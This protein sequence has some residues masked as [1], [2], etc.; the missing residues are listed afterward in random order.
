MSG[1]PQLTFET[2]SP[3]WPFI[4]AAT[5]LHHHEQ[6][7]V[8]REI[9]LGSPQGRSGRLIILWKLR[10]KVRWRAYHIFINCKIFAEGP[11]SRRP[12]YRLK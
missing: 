6:Q 11:K 10:T 9:E 3:S 1:R 4:L 12:S 7:Y 2:R 5:S 8:S